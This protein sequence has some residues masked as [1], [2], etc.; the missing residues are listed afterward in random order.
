[1]LI[2]A[3]LF[4]FAWTIRTVGWRRALGLATEPRHPEDPRLALAG[5]FAVVRCPMGLA[6]ILVLSGVAVAAGSAPLIAVAA[7][8]IGAIVFAAARSEAAL[9]ERHGE[10]YRRYQGAVP[11]LLPRLRARRNT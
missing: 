4:V 5:P 2:A 7:L 11:L 9:V 6:A 1:M 8:A 3:G 10:A